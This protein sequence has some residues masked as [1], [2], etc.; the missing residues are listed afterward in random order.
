MALY[1]GTL[2]QINQK[3]MMRYAGLSPKVKE[4][5]QSAIDEA[6]QEALALAEPKGLWQIFPYEPE[7]GIIAGDTPLQLEGHAIRHHLAH[8]Y[9]VGVMAVTVGEEIEKASSAHFK[10][11]RYLQGLLLDAAATAAVEHLADQV[12]QLIQKE[13]ARYGQKTVWR[14]SPGYGDWP[15]TQQPSFCQ[16]MHTEEI[17]LTVTDHSML[18]PRKSVSAI[19]GISNCARKPSPNKCH[20][21]SLQTCPFRQS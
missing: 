17:G 21:C 3:E 13:A 19:I 9:S 8:S 10:E 12:D 1:N 7:N 5:P 6:I 2:F 14:F 11:G 15:V 4:F 16:L 20:T 18:F